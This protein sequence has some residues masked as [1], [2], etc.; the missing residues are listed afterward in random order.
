MVG[1]VN[2]A[3]WQRCRAEWPGHLLEPNP[4][5]A[6]D[7]GRDLRQL[8]AD[9]ARAGRLRRGYASCSWPIR[10]GRPAT[11][12]RSRAS[13]ARSRL[14]RLTLPN[15]SLEPE[16]LQLFEDA[17]LP[18]VRPSERDYNA[19]INDP[20][21]AK[22]KFL[23]PRRSRARWPTATSTSASARRTR[24][25]RRAPTSSRR[26][27]SAAAGGRRAR[28]GIVLAAPADAATG[29]RPTCP[30]ACGSR[31]SSRT[32][33]T[34]YF[35]AAR[36]GGHGHPTRTARPRRRSPS[37]PTRSSRSPRRVDR[38]ARPASRSSTSWSPARSS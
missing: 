37:W 3:A 36:R 31:P 7:Q 10:S 38:C 16:T 19:T 8:P 14:L 28:R 23:R 12:A 20:R 27:T 29:A 35:A 34:D 33:S 2:E 32:S 18:I 30:T 15:G 26:W 4:S 6:L 17:D 13:T 24:S 21:F 11:P 22:V 25:A 5:A 1:V 9:Q